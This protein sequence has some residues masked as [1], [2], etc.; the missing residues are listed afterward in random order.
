MPS[1]MR[2][3]LRLFYICM[4]DAPRLHHSRITFVSSM[5]LPW[6]EDAPDSDRD[7]LLAMLDAEAAEEVDEA[8]EDSLIPL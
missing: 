8:P 7:A 3:V 4:T 6:Q 1:C 5:P 2:F